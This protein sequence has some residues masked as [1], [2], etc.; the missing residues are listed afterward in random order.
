[1]WNGPTACDGKS[2]GNYQHL[3]WTCVD[4]VPMFGVT[5]FF[6]AAG[7]EAVPANQQFPGASSPVQDGS[8]RVGDKGTIEKWDSRV[9]AYVDTGV[10]A[11]PLVVIENIPGQAKP[12]VTPGYNPATG[13]WMIDQNPD[14]SAVYGV[15]PSNAALVPAALDTVQAAINALSRLLASGQPK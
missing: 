15:P 3:N 6:G 7:Y 11:K 10:E 4:N 13:G 1:M 14:G 5:G 9:G 12:K 8:T 2:N